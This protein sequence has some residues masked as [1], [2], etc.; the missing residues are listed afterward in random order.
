MVDPF[1]ILPLAFSPRNIPLPLF[2]LPR[3]CGDSRKM[4]RKLFPFK[5][6]LS[7]DFV[8]LNH[9]RTAGIEVSWYVHLDWISNLNKCCIA[10]FLLLKTGNTGFYLPTIVIQET[11]LRQDSDVGRKWM[12][13]S[14]IVGWES[15]PHTL[16]SSLLNSISVNEPRPFRENLFWLKL[17]CLDS[18][19]MMKAIF[20][21]PVFGILN[22]RKVQ[23]ARKRVAPTCCRRQPS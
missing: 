8:N 17:F 16:P 23:S 5:L 20:S 19:L 6:V 14:K 9:H 22:G 18:F 12:C 3:S 15:F 7:Q 21:E 10:L 2:L 13:S 1:S 11:G 4:R